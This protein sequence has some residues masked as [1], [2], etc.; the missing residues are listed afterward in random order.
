MDRLILERLLS[1]HGVKKICWEL[2]VGKERVREVRAQALEAGYL[3]NR[4]KSVGPVPVPLTPTIL[5]PNYIDRRTLRS[6]DTD[7]LLLSVR[8]WIED[9]MIA[10][11]SLITVFEELPVQG[12][13]RSG[14]YRFLDRHDLYKVIQYQKDSLIAPILHQP[15]EALILDWGKIR[16]VMD[17]E[18][19]KKRTLWAFVGVMGFSRYMMVRLVWTNSVSITLDAM[20]SMFQ[21]LGGTPSK[22]TSDNPKCF[23]IQADRYDPLLNPALERFSEYYNQFRIECLA[24]YEP[25][26]K[27]KVERMVPFVRRLF[28]AYPKE[29]VSL[30]HAQAYMNKKCNIAN[31]RRHGTTCLKPIEEFHLK[32]FQCLKPLPALAY[33]R[34]AVAYPLVRKDGFV[35]FDNKYYA[36]GDAFIG[37]K[38][39]VVGTKSRISIFIGGELVETYNRITSPNTTHAIQEHLKKPWQKFEENCAHYLTRADLI[40]PGCGQFVRQVLEQGDGF[41]DTRIIWG[42]LALDKRYN[43]TSI[44]Q[45]CAVACNAGRLSSRYVAD[46]LLMDSNSKLMLSGSQPAMEMKKQVRNPIQETFKFARPMSVY[47]E[48]VHQQAQPGLAV[49]LNQQE[50]QT[51][52]QQ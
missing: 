20:E 18:T 24:P 52:S 44:D 34:E 9:R 14:F 19:G 36:V 21:E 17:T 15:G 12:I 13:S 6:S 32:E 46:L 22:M 48:R 3:A 8:P 33:E 23:S 42:V 30:E 37:K 50:Q 11:W 28:E 39:V 38:S 41:V 49:L 7:Q 10:G 5:F 45:A 51:T 47:M 16:D 2:K 4:G 40:G 29:F 27:G 25:K 1:K 31:E 26:K 43:P 35:R